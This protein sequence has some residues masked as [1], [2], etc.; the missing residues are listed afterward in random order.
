MLLIALQHLRC[1]NPGHTFPW[2]SIQY[3][4]SLGYHFMLHWFSYLLRHTSSSFMPR[5]KCASI[6]ADDQQIPPDPY[7]LVIEASQRCILYDTSSTAPFCTSGR[8]FTVSVSPP[9][10]LACLASF[11]LQSC[12]YPV[13][14][15]FTSVKI[16]CLAL[17]VTTLSGVFCS[18]HDI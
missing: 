9:H 18:T 3:V 8:L 4:I 1:W 7:H 16:S 2:T 14:Y 13:S 5:S 11:R 6:T 15:R 17:Y 10:M 12:S